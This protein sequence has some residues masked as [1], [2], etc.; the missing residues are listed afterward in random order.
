[1]PFTISETEALK[2]DAAAVVARY[3]PDAA[4]LYGAALVTAGEHRTRL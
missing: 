3:F 1:M 2:R 4:A